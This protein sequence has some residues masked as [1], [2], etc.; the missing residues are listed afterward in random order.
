MM[1]KFKILFIRALLTEL[2]NWDFYRIEF[3]CKLSEQLDI[4]S[5]IRS[6]FKNEEYIMLVLRSDSQVM[7]DI[8]LDE[9]GETLQWNTTFKLQPYR[10]V[11][12]L[13]NVLVIGINSTEFISFS[14]PITK[15]V[16]PKPK[17]PKLTVVK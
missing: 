8:E 2:E 14:T 5:H 15:P 1:N 9:L 17:K 10:V 3:H 6:E 11:I 13:E 16:P 12:P 4:P 7:L